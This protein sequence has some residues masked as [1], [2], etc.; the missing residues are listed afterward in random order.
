M[1]M[2]DGISRKQVKAC[3]PPQQVTDNTPVVGTIID[4]Q[5]YDELSYLIEHDTNDEVR[6]REGRGDRGRLGGRAN[7]R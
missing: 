1:S 7:P 3:I 5:G 2:R 4:R 6:R